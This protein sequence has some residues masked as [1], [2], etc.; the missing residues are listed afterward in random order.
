MRKGAIARLTWDMLDSRAWT[1]TLPGAITKNKARQ[2]LKLQ[3]EVKAIMERRIRARRLDSP[4]IFH[5]RSKGRNGR[6]VADSSRRWR[7]ALGDANLPDG[8][9]FHDLRRS[10]VRTLIRSGVDP[11]VAMK[12]SGHKTRSMLDRYNIIA[13]QETAAAF[14]KADEYLSTQPTERNLSTMPAAAPAQNPHKS[15][16]YTA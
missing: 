1:L 14:A 7:K 10:A 8:L 4:L 3:G 5:R 12:V 11:S 16:R 15:R 13:E 2:V 6:P 9:L